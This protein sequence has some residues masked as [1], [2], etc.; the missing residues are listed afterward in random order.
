M[1]IDFLNS[2][3]TRIWTPEQADAFEGI[4]RSIYEQ[5]WVPLHVPAFGVWKDALQ[6][7]ASDLHQ[8]ASSVFTFLFITLRPLVLLLYMVIEYIIRFIWKYVIVQGFSQQG[9]QYL[10]AGVKALYRHQRSLT[11]EQL[12]IEVFVIAGAV[13]LYQIRRFL[14]RQTYIQRSTAYVRK[15]AKRLLDSYRQSQKSLSKVS[16]FYW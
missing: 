7:A 16:Y 8:A 1:M 12:A 4:C 10:V 2:L 11:R 5:V 9:V 3:S 13:L 14:Q 15:Q 6:V